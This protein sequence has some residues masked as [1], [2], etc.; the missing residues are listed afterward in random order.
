M[1]GKKLLEKQELLP[2]GVG[3]G[4]RYDHFG[5]HYAQGGC[6]YHSGAMESEPQGSQGAELGEQGLAPEI[7]SGM[8]DGHYHC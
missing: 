4:S 2:L 7:G 5:C 8:V 3:Q 6:G 1:S